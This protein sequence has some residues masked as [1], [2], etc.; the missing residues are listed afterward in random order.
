MP[1]LLI[2]TLGTI[3]IHLHLVEEEEESPNRLCH[4]PKLR[5]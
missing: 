4:L 2:E 5:S 1:H 3:I